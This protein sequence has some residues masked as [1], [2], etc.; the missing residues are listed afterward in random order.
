MGLMDL[1][2]HIAFYYARSYKSEQ[3][4]DDTREIND[5]KVVG[6]FSLTTSSEALAQEI[7]SQ[8]S[9]I[10]SQK[11]VSAQI[12][13]DEFNR[14]RQTANILLDTPLY[15]DHTSDLS[16]VEL[17]ARARRLRQ[18]RGLDL[19]IVEHLEA[20]SDELGAPDNP[21]MIIP[22]AKILADLA[23][24]LEVPIITFTRQSDPQKLRLS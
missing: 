24:E 7:L 2:L 13:D 14:L 22:I 10:P 16:V 3:Q 12:T 11:I 5:Y 20:L 4:I 9:E 23:E 8:Q 18:Q 17:A 15:L 19:I 6:F 21:Q 1:I